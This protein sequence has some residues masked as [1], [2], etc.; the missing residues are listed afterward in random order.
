MKLQ[1]KFLFK[2]R[3]M[4][5]K[6][7]GVK[8][9]TSNDLVYIELGRSDIISRIKD[10]QFMFNEK[11]SQVTVEEAILASAYEMC[12]DLPII[13]CYKKLRSDNK[14]INKTN[15]INSVK[16]SNASMCIRYR[17]LCN[18]DIPNNILYDSYINDKY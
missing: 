15:R 16:I 2:K 17:Q 5:K 11:I 13:S 9:G 18:L 7:L 6:I 14:A 4:I 1:K 8:Q 3:K 10:L 12:K